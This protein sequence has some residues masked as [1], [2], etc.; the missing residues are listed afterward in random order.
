M[1]RQPTVGLLLMVC[2][3]TA[4]LAI[5]ASAAVTLTEFTAQARPD[6]T[7]RV[8]WT[9]A[10]ELST[11]GFDLYRSEGQAGPPWG[12][13][14]DEEPARGT[15]PT[16]WTYTFSDDTVTSG[17]TYY[18]LLEEL[19]VDDSGGTYGPVN[20][21]AGQVV[22]VTAT[23]T[24]TGTPTNT[25]VPG[26]SPTATRTPTSTATATPPPDSHPTATREFTNTPPPLPTG[27][28]TEESL[29]V[30]TPTLRP[31]A[32]VL[33]VAVVETPTGQAPRSTTQPS[34]P[35]TPTVAMIAEGATV[36]SPVDTPSV[37]PSAESSEVATEV[38]PTPSG[39]M[40]VSVTPA[41]VFGP[42][43][44][45]GPL[46][47]GSEVSVQATPGTAATADLARDTRLVSILGGG[48]IV[49][50]LVM[51]VV[52]ILVWRSRRV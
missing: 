20:A 31:T 12:D 30:P 39:T 5:P 3:M 45:Q 21:T 22:T 33:P 7:I 51:G 9:T 49:L 48:A 34:E 42:K 50:A 15:G 10:T 24:T 13:P 11:I 41:A 47:R 37:A 2:V 26:A 4:L 18:Y 32:T 35:P 44:T 36:T 17:T 27:T 8:R 14:I 6:S 38:V 16:G 43:E 23:A 19:T 25:P 46:L 52:A 28:P 40:A 1:W 29:Q